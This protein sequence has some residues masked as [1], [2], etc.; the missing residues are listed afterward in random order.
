MV[1]GVLAVAVG[2]ERA[3]KLALPPL[4]VERGA[5][6][7]GDVAAIFIIY[8]VLERYEQ[9]VYRFRIEKAVYMV[10]D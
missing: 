8:D 4:Q 9:A 2:R 1:V 5:D 6:L 10:A 7:V 3:D